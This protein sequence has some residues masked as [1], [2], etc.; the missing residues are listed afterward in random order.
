MVAQARA[1][2]GNIF[3]SRNTP[4]SLRGR[5]R[6]SPDYGKEALVVTPL[7]LRFHFFLDAFR[8]QKNVGIPELKIPTTSSRTTDQPKT[9]DKGTTHESLPVGVE[10][11]T[12]A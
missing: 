3:K 11:V 8:R 4:K 2:S 1:G 7:F 10:A 9:F 5:Q 12:F 6:A